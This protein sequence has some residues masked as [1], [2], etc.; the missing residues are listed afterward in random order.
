MI[1][2]SGNRFFGQ[3]RARNK[4]SRPRSYSVELDHGLAGKRKARY[5]IVIRLTR[6]KLPEHADDDTTAAAAVYPRNRRAKGARRRGRL[7]HARSGTR[8]RSPTRPRAAGAIAPNFS[9]ARGHRGVPDAANGRASSTIGS[10]RKC[11][12]FTDNHI[13]VRFAYEW[14]DDSGHWFRSYGNEQWE[15]DEHGLMRRRDASIND[16]PIAEKD[17]LFHW[18]LGPRP[19]DHKGLSELGL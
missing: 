2:K 19:A 4:K 13:A 9:G 6:P 8:R 3:D 17:R 16:L 11:G 1:R 7:E 15:F 10:S 14:H 18:P 12:P 5:L